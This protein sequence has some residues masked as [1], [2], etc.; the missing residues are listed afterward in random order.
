ARGVVVGG[1]WALSCLRAGLHLLHRRLDT[2]W[3]GRNRHPAVTVGPCC[4]ERQWTVGCDIN[5]NLVVEIDEVTVAMK[6]FYLAR[7]AA[8]GIV[9]LFAFEQRAYNA[10]IF[11]KLLD[12]YRVLSHNSQTR[13]W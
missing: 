11:A 3:I 8:V 4:L 2:Q 5:R 10:Q 9:D 7:F 13:K 6:E 12:R 1:Q